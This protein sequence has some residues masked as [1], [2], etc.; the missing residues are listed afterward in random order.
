VT[1]APDLL[2]STLNGM[3]NVGKIVSFVGLHA[4]I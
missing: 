2:V 4:D 3:R 1:A